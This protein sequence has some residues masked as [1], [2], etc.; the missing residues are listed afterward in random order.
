MPKN[1]CHTIAAKGEGVEREYLDR[2]VQ[3]KNIN[4]FSPVESQIY[5]AANLNDQERAYA[6]WRYENLNVMLWALANEIC[7][8]S[9]IVTAIFQPS[10][11]AFENSVTLRNTSEILDELD[12]IYRMNWACIDARIKNQPTTG[13]L[14]ASIVYERHYSLN[15]LTQYQNQDWDDVQTNT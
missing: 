5:K 15:W 10:R 13:N 8:V 2:T 4:S 11:E 7:N 1:L 6:T 12:K 14:D 9:E 3:E